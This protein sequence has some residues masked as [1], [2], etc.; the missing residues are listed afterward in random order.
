MFQNI[1]LKIKKKDYFENFF[2]S[3]FFN[4]KNYQIK[5]QLIKNYHLRCKS[6]KI[7]ILV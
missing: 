2:M 3:N 5:E 7:I 1:H 6:Y 4:L